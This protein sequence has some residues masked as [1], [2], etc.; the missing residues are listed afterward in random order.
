MVSTTVQKTVLIAGYSLGYI[1]D[2]L[3]QSFHRKGLRVFA[4][5]RDFVQGS[6][7]EKDGHDCVT[8]RYC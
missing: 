4:T 3:T 6:A 7:S 2:A 8:L 5:A 1:R